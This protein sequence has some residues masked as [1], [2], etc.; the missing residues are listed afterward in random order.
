MNGR[1]SALLRCGL[2]FGM[3]MGVRPA[4]VAS[5]DWQGAVDGT[6]HVTAE[7]THL[8]ENSRLNPGNALARLATDSLGVEARL[9]LK[10]AS[11]AIRLSVRPILPV[12]WTDDG[13]ARGTWHQGHV[14]QWQ[15]GFRLGQE[16]TLG[17][18]RERMNWG[19]AQFRSPSSPFY[20]DNGRDNPSQELSGV[21]MVKLVHTPS[22][23][24]IYT[25]AWIQDSGH[26]ATPDD[27]WRHTWLV[28]AERR[29][30]A[31]AAALVVAR[32]QGREPF[33]GMFAQWLVHDDWLLYGE[34]A[35]A[36]RAQA[37][38][39]PADP[40]LPFALLAESSRHLTALLGAS[41][42]FES[43]RSV[44]IELL[45][46]GHGYHQ[47]AADSYFARAA[48][49]LPEAGLALGRIPPLLGRHYL[50]MVWQ[51]SPLDDT[52]YWRAQWSR[53]LDDDS[54][55]VALYLERPIDARTS[56]YALGV[57]GAGGPEREFSA[58]IEHRLLLGLRMAFP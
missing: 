49:S 40:A 34:A 43:G 36:T 7:T 5:D 41:H 9:N 28:K 15:A 11:D 16:L 4:A 26:Q 53:N 8:A 3:A 10:L 21:D 32:A 25:L 46:D 33:A 13:M 50:Q 51:N 6:F 19:P 39:S 31:W 47:D 57:L 44:S 48:R 52:G 30:D 20:F 14:S 29:A 54:N 45:H 55:E 56:F 42:T 1:L 12:R 27:P 2:I 18:G 23:N 24:S 37:L 22:T 58:L 17:V 35:S 38:A